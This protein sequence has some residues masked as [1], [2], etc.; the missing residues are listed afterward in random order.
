MTLHFPQVFPAVQ[1]AAAGGQ[2]VEQ[3]VVGQLL[4][5]HDGEAW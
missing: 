3:P 2:V 1:A 4:L 5:A